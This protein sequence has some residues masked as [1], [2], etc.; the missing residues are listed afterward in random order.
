MELTLKEHKELIQ[1]LKENISDISKDERRLE[2]Y[3]SNQQSE[4]FTLK[5][6]VKSQRLEIMNLKDL[7]EQYHLRSEN[8]KALIQRILLQL[9]KIKDEHISLRR[10]VID[11][12]K[13]NEYYKDK[14]GIDLDHLT[15]RPDWSR[16]S[17]TYNAPA[18]SNSI[19]IEFDPI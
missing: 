15:P 19:I 18:L 1:S 5:D 3:I 13:E 7:N 17:T 8:N 11:L 10:T 14:G 16:L 4:F 2:D 12:N 9:Y 6:Q